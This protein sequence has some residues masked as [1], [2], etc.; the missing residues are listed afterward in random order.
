M[1][2]TLDFSFCIIPDNSLEAC[3]RIS[4][5]VK[6]IRRLKIPNYEILVI[7]GETNKFSGNLEDFTKI[8][9]D[10]S[11]K[12][13]WV[14]KKKNDVAR[15]AK[16]DNLVICHDY[17]VFHRNWY[18]GYLKIYNDFINCDVCCNPVFMIDGRRQF[19]DWVTWDHPCLGR[20][21]PL[22]YSDWSQTRYQYIHG[23]YYVTKR[24]FFLNNPLN[25]EFIHG[26]PEDVE[27]SLR[28]RDK[29]KIIC[30]SYSYCWHNKEHKDL[31]ID[32]NLIWSKMS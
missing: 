7:G 15:L 29:S 30:N 12:P 14:S 8:N 1:S 24:D 10:E 31:K 22:N 3:K 26:Q 25:E 6:S 5:M 4:A 11:E 23:A 9:F 21:S 16:H 32:F 18:K 17:F 27:W 19:V 20:H 13:A 2:K 28:I